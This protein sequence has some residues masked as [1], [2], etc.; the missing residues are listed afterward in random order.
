[1]TEP[2]W[3]LA[4]S[5]FAFIA[6]L[7]GIPTVMLSALMARTTGPQPV[8]FAT[9]VS[10]AVII[11]FLSRRW[12]ALRAQQQAGALPAPAG[13]G[14][15]FRLVLGPPLQAVLWWLGSCVAGMA[16]VIVPWLLR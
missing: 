2:H 10:V 14:D 1:M 4:W 15:V 12:S 9:P 5:R 7:I 16:V 11:L 6:A 13:A 3:K 8:V